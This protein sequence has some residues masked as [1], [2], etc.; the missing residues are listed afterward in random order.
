MNDLQ[1]MLRDFANTKSKFFE[2]RDGQEKEVR[3]LDAEVVPNHF[4]GGKTTCVRFHLEVEGA[5]QSWDR[6]S[7]DLVL[8]MS[9]IPKGSLIRIRRTGDKSKTKYFVERIEE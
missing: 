6:I 4:D 2:L 3:Y 5:A 7:R 1:K 9:R 8:Q